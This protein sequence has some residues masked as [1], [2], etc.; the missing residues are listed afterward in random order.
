VGRWFY[1][2]VARDTNGVHHLVADF[3]LDNQS[4]AVR[5]LKLGIAKDV[6]IGYLSAGR[7]CDLCGASVDKTHTCGNGH[8]LNQDYDGKRCTVTYSGDLTRVQALEGSLVGVGCLYDAEV[9]G[10]KA[11]GAGQVLAT[12]GREDG[13]N[14]AQ[15]AELEA[16]VK[17]LREENEKLTREAGLIEDG[18]QYRTDLLAEIERKAG[19]LERDIE[20]DKSLLSGA[21]LATIK[22]YDAQLEKALNDKFPPTPQSKML[23]AGA[24]KLP[25]LKDPAP[26]NAAPGLRTSPFH[27]WDEEK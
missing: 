20:L 8:R 17:V 7:S 22:K 18:R 4:E 12:F 3:Y 14:E 13:M 23:G 15:F 16:E 9:I 26:A 2:S 21:P 6:S 1:A 10:G 11:E 19:V 27:M 25:E 24:D 5:S